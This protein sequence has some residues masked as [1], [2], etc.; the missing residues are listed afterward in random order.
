MPTISCLHPQLK[1]ILQGEAH[2]IA[3]EKE[4]QAFLKLLM[5]TADCQGMLIGLEGGTTKGERKKRAPSEYND[6]MGKCA[7]S[8]DKVVDGVPGQGKDFKACALEWK[9]EHPKK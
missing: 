9:K 8:K 5:A 6:F 3:D 4:R 1:L 2:H 7:R